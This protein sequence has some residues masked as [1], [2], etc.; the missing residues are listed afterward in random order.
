[1][2]ALHRGIRRGLVR[3]CHDLS[4]GGLAVA[5]AEMA[6]AGRLGAELSLAALPRAAGVDRDDSALFSESAGRFLV[7]VAPEDAPALEEAL[8]GIPH[9][10]L[11]RVV[12]EDR[13]EV[14]GLNGIP[15]LSCAV[16]DLGRA[17]KEVA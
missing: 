16:P 4:E 9:G 8:A 14:C 11:G 13:F 6:L 3:A 10:C 1:M 5:A 2:R 15:V 7:E 17:W 12:Q